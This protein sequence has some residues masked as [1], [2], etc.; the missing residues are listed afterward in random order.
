MLPILGTILLSAVGQIGFK[1]AMDVGKKLFGKSGAGS[2]PTPE[3]FSA[4]LKKQLDQSTA[5]PAAAVA[6]TLAQAPQGLQALAPSVMTDVPVAAAVSAYRRLEK[7]WPGR[8]VETGL[9]SS[10]QAP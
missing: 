7:A 8:S 3:S 10:Q 9:I 1:L 6:P 5:A 4:Q 2:T